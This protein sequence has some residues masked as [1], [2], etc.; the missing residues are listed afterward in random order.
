MSSS[1]IK[2]LYAIKENT[3]RQAWEFGAGSDMEK[4]LIGTGRLIA[5]PDGSYEVFTKEATEGKGQMAHIGDFFKVDEIGFPSPCER[6]WFKKNH[7][8]IEGNWYLQTA[9][10]LK[11]WR[12]GDP[13]TEEYRFL[14]A[15]G[16]LNVNTEDP[17]KY[18]SAFLWGTKETA[19]ENATIV[20]YSINRDEDEKITSI[21]F[22]FVDAEYFRNNYRIL[23]ADEASTL[24]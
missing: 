7:K 18:F 10:P 13:E 8:H 19:P 6:D 22:N 23:S 9:K 4:Q 11:I 1:E 2:S 12:K 16:A 15:S 20:F 17:S 5:H 24:F 3:K 21:I 14:I